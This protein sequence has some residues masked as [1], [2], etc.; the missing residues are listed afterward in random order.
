MGSMYEI[1]EP[2]MML[3]GQGKTKAK[4]AKGKATRKGRRQV[5][6]L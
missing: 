1:E 5:A 3:A 4:S 2:C 6:I